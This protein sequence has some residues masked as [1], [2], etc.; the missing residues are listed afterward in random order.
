MGSLVTSLI[1][2]YVFPRTQTSENELKIINCS[3]EYK[4]EKMLM[5][6]IIYEFEKKDRNG[7]ILHLFKAVKLLKIVKIPDALKQSQKLMDKQTQIN[8]ALWENHVEA[9]SMMARI[10]N[11]GDKRALGLMQL[12]GVQG[13]AKTVQDAKEIADSDFAGLI[14]VIQGSFRSIEYGLLTQ[15]EAEWV[16]EKMANM[17]YIEMIRG[18]PAA[19]NAGSERNSKN[20]VGDNGAASKAGDTTSEDTSEEFA[21]GLSGHDFIALTLSSPIKYKVLENWLSLTSRKQTDWASIMQGSNSLSAGINI[22]VMFAGNLG[23]S[24][25]ASDGVSDSTSESI[26][27]SVGTS[28]SDSTSYSESVGLSEGY[29]TGRTIGTTQGVT[30]GVTNG[31][32]NGITNGTTVGQTQGVTVGHTEG[33]TIGHTEGTTLGYSEGFSHTLSEGESY[34]TGL[35]FSEGTSTSVSF[36]ESMGTSASQ[37]QGQSQGFSS[38]TSESFSQSTGTSHTEG[39]S[40]SHSLSAG[41]GTSY[42]QGYGYG[43]GSSYG[44]SS[45]DA[46]STNKGDTWSNSS[47]GSFANNTGASE[48]LNA[49]NSATNSNGYNVGG[50]L[51]VTGSVNSSSSNSNTL[52]NGY[53]STNGSNFGYSYGGGRGGSAGMGYSSGAGQNW[54][55]SNSGSVSYGQ[56]FSA[57]NSES[58][59]SGFSTSDGFSE[60]VSYGMGSTSG[61]SSSTSMSSS[62]GQTHS[63]SQSQGMGTSSSQ[64]L[65]LSEGVS[66]SESYGMSYSNSMSKSMSVSNSQSSS[67]SLSRSNSNSFSTS[68]SN[69][70]SVSQSNSHSVSRS[71]SYSTSESNSRTTSQSVSNGIGHSKGTSSSDGV[72]SGRSIGKSSSTSNTI[73]NG[74]SASM[75]VGASVSIG[76]TYQ[77]IDSEVANIVEMFEFQKNRLKQAI[78]GNTGAWFVDMYIATETREAQA[79][80]K[81]VAKSAWYNKDSIICPLQVIDDLT[82]EEQQNMLYHFNAFSASPQK[83]RDRFGMFESYRY[84]SIL[85]S[86]EMTAYTHPLRL[87]DGGIYAD[88]QNIPELAVPS[89]LQGEVFMGKIV[90]AYKWTME[91]G[92]VTKFDYRISNDEIMHSLFAAGSRSGKT[93][94]ALRFVSEIANN[95]RRKSGKRMRIVALD[96]KEDWRSL[97]NFVEP[98]RFRIYNM[99]DPN[100]FPFVLN[101]L[102]V[103]LGVDPE[104]HLN[105]LI[106]VFCRAYGLGI[107]SVMIMKDIFMALYNQAG[108][109]SAETP[110][111]ITECSSRCTL[112]MAYDKLVEEKAGYSR[113][114]AEAADKVL[115]RLNGFARENGIM[116]KLYSQTEGIS[117]DEMLGKDDVIVLE[118]GKVTSNDMT[119]LF[120]FITA[121]IYMYAKYCDGN[122]LGEDQYETM[123]V[124]EEANRVLT[125]EKAGESSGGIQGQSIFEEML[126]Q[127]AGLGIFVTSITQ[128]PAQM[129]TSIIANSGLIF[130]GKLKN[131]DD[132]EIA[133]SAQGKELRY[134]NR[135]IKTF[136]PK[137]PIGW[138]IAQSSRTFDYKQGEATLIKVSALNSRKPTNA[139]L[140]EMMLLNRVNQS[141]SE[142]Q[143]YI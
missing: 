3:I 28:E 74:T 4:I 128:E 95:I 12:Y 122:F 107:R 38:S 117:I 40:S 84:S 97:A 24:L 30:E 79:K 55:I 89:N 83:E 63:F 106:D 123:L 19:K 140:E 134:T 137:C 9:I 96:P 92:Y 142:S 102:K 126:D 82:D 87:S 125:G 119:F 42:N 18:I 6:Y 52:S 85:T 105:T 110:E 43:T 11:T 36:G 56:G 141:I 139:E 45:N 132:I 104:F 57:S 5:D 112:K 22:P 103:S 61:T 101:P 39:A 8:A 1:D 34:N 118:S 70:H 14:A 109:F 17:K 86:A 136:M 99:G 50:E 60:G 67:D 69:S 111:E 44:M 64:S 77:F 68:Q 124:I 72:S 46:W 26:S 78:H 53:G 49:G 58:Y 135:E 91:D 25:G 127:A 20:S 113:D 31:V 121:S 37:S 35:G 131:S 48:N 76:K 62:F 130:S 138:F 7:E 33:T 54:G 80:A 73:S 129:P 116:R 81:A 15:E 133:L 2:K 120:G 32:T 16:R 23:S 51:G 13:V 59:G 27:H 66:R 98:E 71:N 75:G 100:K 88:I 143:Q 114:K 93:V 108:V 115:D 47:S 21:V 65:S 41:T 90:S 94:A 29:T 10:E